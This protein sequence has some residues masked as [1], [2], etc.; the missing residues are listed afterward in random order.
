MYNTVHY[1]DCLLFPIERPWFNSLFLYWVLNIQKEIFHYRNITKK[2]ILFEGAMECIRETFQQ[3]ES[4]HQRQDHISRFQ[5]R[6][7]ETQ[8]MRH[9]LRNWIRRNYSGRNTLAYTQYCASLFIHSHVSS[10]W[11]NTVLEAAILDLHTLLA[12]GT[13]HA[14]W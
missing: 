10:T 7:Q 14:Y 1:L 12:L 6:F 4:Y 3:H 9:S 8:Q 11:A 2:K 13:I 5:I